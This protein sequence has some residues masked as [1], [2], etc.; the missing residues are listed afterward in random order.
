METNQKPFSERRD[1][2][3]SG[4]EIVIRTLSDAWGRKLR[5]ATKEEDRVHHVD[6]VDECGNGIQSKLR[7]DKKQWND[8]GLAIFEPLTTL[9]GHKFHKA[10]RPRDILTNGVYDPSKPLFDQFVFPDGGKIGRDID[11]PCKGFASLSNC[12]KVVRYADAPILKSKYVFP[13]LVNW[14]E[15]GQPIEHYPR[16]NKQEKDADRAFYPTIPEFRN[17]ISIKLV[18]DGSSWNPKLIMYIKPELLIE[19]EEIWYFPVSSDQ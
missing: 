9:Y 11:K 8:L 6:I 13:S 3:N 15:E 12:V 17:M 14:F 18:I 2:G 7:D 5:P 1:I 16:K 19:G 4:E 10:V